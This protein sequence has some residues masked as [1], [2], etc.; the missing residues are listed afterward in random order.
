VRLTRS[1]RYRRLKSAAG[2]K[3]VPTSCSAHGLVRRGLV[4]ERN[5]ITQLMPLVPRTD[6]VVIDR[7]GDHSV[8]ILKIASTLVTDGNPP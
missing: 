6:V 3:L 1:G 8:T 5:L 7:D 2:G 4:T